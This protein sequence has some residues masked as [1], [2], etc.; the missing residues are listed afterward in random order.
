MDVWRTERMLHRHTNVSSVQQISPHTAT[1]KKG[2]GGSDYLFSAGCFSFI[3]LTPACHV[4]NDRSNN[5]YCHLSS[6]NY[7]VLKAVKVQKYAHHQTNVRREATDYDTS[8]YPAGG[9]SV[10]L[11][12]AIATATSSPCAGHPNG[13]KQLAEL[14]WTTRPLSEKWIYGKTHC[15]CSVHQSSG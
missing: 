13:S 1:T 15:I 2:K 11:L 6:K 8:R 10:P 3:K 12:R 9:A 4:Q 5:R 14:T 7:T